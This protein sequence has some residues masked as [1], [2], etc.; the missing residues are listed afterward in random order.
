M[1]PRNPWQK[2]ILKYC[3]S[4]FGII[5]N[6]QLDKHIDRACLFVACLRCKS[7][8]KS[9]RNPRRNTCAIICTS[10][11]MKD[12][13]VLSAKFLLIF[14]GCQSRWTFLNLQSINLISLQLQKSQ[15]VN[16]IFLPLWQLKVHSQVPTWSSAR[17]KLIKAIWF[18]L[19]C[20]F[21]TLTPARTHFISELKYQLLK[22]QFFV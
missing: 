20:S 5:Q 15:R 14:Y 19:H 22:L 8:R 2:K 17:S 18:L 3:D 1:S 10:I 7:R 9:R 13:S 21:F 4:F 11:K 12:F 16:R 6:I